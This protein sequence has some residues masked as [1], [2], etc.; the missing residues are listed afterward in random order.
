MNKRLPERNPEDEGRRLLDNMVLAKKKSREESHQNYCD[1]SRERLRKNIETKI[2]TT[3]IGSLSQIENV[4]GFLWGHGKRNGQPLTE[5]EENMQ[6]LFDKLRTEILNL[7]NNQIRA[8][9]AEIDQYVVDWQ[10]YQYNLTSDGWSGPEGPEAQ[11][12]VRKVFGLRED[13]TPKKLRYGTN[14]DGS[15]KTKPEGQDNE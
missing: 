10:R 14:S 9:K 6:E 15:I 3:M 7:G 5:A 1:R 11:S 12:D 8:A 2:R 13:W 4:F